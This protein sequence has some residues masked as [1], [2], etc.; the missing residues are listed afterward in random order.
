MTANAI[1]VLIETL[2]AAW[3]AL[4]PFLDDHFPQAIAMDERKV[5]FDECAS[6]LDQLVPHG[7]VNEQWREIAID[8]RRDRNERQRRH[9][10]EQF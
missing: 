1:E 6:V 9:R 10:G 8:N 4:D 2:A 5:I 7:W 3:A